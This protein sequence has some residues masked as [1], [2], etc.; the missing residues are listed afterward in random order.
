MARTFS[1]VVHMTFLLLHS[2]NE[3]TMKRKKKT[4]TGEH[5]L[6][7]LKDIEF[8]EYYDVLQKSLESMSVFGDSIL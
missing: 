6:E 4:M 5:V 2:S 8:D 7:A 1:D 3:V